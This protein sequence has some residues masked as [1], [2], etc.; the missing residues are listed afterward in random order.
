MPKLCD[1][2]PR[3]LQNKLLEDSSRNT[4]LEERVQREITQSTWGR[5]RRLRV[6][7]VNGNL[8]VEG[9]T[10]SY[11]VKQLAIKAVMEVVATLAQTPSIVIEISLDDGLIRPASYYHR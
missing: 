2:L 3:L 10:T 8:T 7:A 6:E 9:L 11:Y 1:D 4:E 5:V